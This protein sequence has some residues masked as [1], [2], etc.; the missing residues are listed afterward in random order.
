VS[1][2]P[3]QES[4]GVTLVSV[5]V[6]LPSLMVALVSVVAA[7]VS[8]EV[9]VVVPSTGVITSKLSAPAASAKSAMTSSADPT[10]TERTNHVI[11]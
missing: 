3:A 6:E 4:S 10:P 5:V 1:T 8:V 11:G 7:L 9:T 2:V